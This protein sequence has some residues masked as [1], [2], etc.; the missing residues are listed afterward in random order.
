M[1]GLDLN[2]KLTLVDTKGMLVGSWFASLTYAIVLFQFGLYIRARAKDPI[3][4]KL[5]LCLL[6]LLDT[7]WNI[8]L[9][10]STYRQL[11]TVSAT[12]LDVYIP[13][14]TFVCMPLIATTSLF[15]V[16]IFLV[17]RYTMLTKRMWIG[18]GLYA[19]SCATFVCYV[20][21]I[22]LS[23]KLRN[24]D[25]SNLK[26]FMADFQVA[27]KVSKAG[28]CLEMVMVC[29]IWLLLG[30]ALLG[31]LRK[32]MLG[33]R[34]IVVRLLLI[35][36][37]T[38]TVASVMCVVQLV[39]F[40]KNT[41]SS[42]LIILAMFTSRIYYMGM[43]FTLNMRGN[44]GQVMREGSTSRPSGVFGESNSLPLSHIGSSGAGS[45]QHHKII[46]VSRDVATVMDKQEGVFRLDDNKSEAYGY[47]GVGKVHYSNGREEGRLRQ[48]M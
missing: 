6:L 19:L 34:R 12:S 27:D 29:T 37:E 7:T 48:E 45:G 11:L 17:W 13:P 46:H 36:A 26:K 40:L 18:Y 31:Y 3:L 9:L 24:F 5:A 30:I 20:Y 41:A 21:A 33:T 39:Y 38:G 10:V 47:D 22:S 16:N 25:L 44:G 8:L 1:D 42:N 32:E 15:G 4:L 23:I 28:I 14:L 43:M 2:L 35:T